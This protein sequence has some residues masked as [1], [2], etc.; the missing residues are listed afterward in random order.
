MRRKRVPYD[1]RL[2]ARYVKSAASLFVLPP[3]ALGGGGT[4]AALWRL[5]RALQQSPP[6]KH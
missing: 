6:G 3:T 2:P 5:E 4:F 1:V